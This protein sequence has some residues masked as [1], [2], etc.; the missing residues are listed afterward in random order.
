MNEALLSLLLMMNEYLKTDLF[1]LSLKL[2]IPEKI[3]GQS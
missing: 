1:K 3:M 2:T